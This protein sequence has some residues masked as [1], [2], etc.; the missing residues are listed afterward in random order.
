VDIL[1]SYILGSAGLDR[2]MKRHPQLTEALPALDIAD[3]DADIADDVD[4]GEA[5]D[6]ITVIKG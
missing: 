6:I 5:S 3:V 4:K 1:K 2:V